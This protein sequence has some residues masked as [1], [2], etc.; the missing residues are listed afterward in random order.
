MD[1]SATVSP[2]PIPRQSRK[3]VI[4]L[5]I[6]ALLLLAL[7]VIVRI[8]TKVY[9]VPTGAMAPTY[10]GGDHVLV[11]RWAYA[12]SEPKRGDAVIFKFR[13]PVADPA[14]DQI[15]LMRIVGLPGETIRLKEGKIHVGDATTPAPELAG[16][17]YT[18]SRAGTLHHY[19]GVTVPGGS[20][21][22]LGDNTENSYDS[23]YWGFVKREDIV[24]RISA[25]LGTLGRPRPVPR[26]PPAG[27]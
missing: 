12:F 7:G 25:N 27:R 16:H 1:A 13:P 26:V 19:Q 6:G 17:T 3:R 9:L 20:Y 8:E 21:F 4:L 5:V 10:V 15:Y 11:N 14:G 22:V 23:R 2:P 18:D 24:G